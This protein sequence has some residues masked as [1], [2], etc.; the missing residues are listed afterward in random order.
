MFRL[1]F[2][3]TSVERHNY[4][5]LLVERLSET[6]FE[7][8]GSFLHTKMLTQAIICN[9]HSKH[10]EPSHRVLDHCTATLGIDG[11][12]RLAKKSA[13]IALTVDNGSGTYP[14]MIPPGGTSNWF[15][16]LFL[17]ISSCPHP[18]PGSH[19]PRI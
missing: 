9:I 3:Q 16:R 17:S 5:P 18:P 6:I 13:H 10:P 12:Y 2:L 19:P 4:D 7:I 11:E 1:L 15:R 14:L 8:N